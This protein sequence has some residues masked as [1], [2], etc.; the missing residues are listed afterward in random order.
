MKA[1][2]SSIVTS[3]ITKLEKCFPTQELLNA[4]NVIYPQYWF[5]PKAKV[6]FLKHMAIIQAHFTRP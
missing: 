4:T 1:Q 6:V 2:Y 5:V 3:L